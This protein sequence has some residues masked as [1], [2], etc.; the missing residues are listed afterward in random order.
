MFWWLMV[1]KYSTKRTAIDRRDDVEHPC[2]GNDNQT[3]QT[4]R[5]GNGFQEPGTP[6]GMNCKVKVCE[7]NTSN[8]SVVNF[9]K[10]RSLF[11]K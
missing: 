6:S 4:S 8:L 2:V 11:V 9:K 5:G 1:I 7:L 3:N 10:T